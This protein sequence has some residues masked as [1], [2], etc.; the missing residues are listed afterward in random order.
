MGGQPQAQDVPDFVHLHVHTHFS[1]LDGACRLE[2]LVDEA[3]ADGQRALGVTDH[4]NL[5]GAVPFYQACTAKGLKPI[6]GIEGYLAERSRLERANPEDN[7]TFHL[8]LLARNDAGWRNLIKLSSLAFKEGF[9]RRPR[10]DKEVLARHS[11]GIVCLTGCL[12]GEI[13]QHIL[14]GDADGA[15][16]SA[17]SFVDIFGREDVYL[18]VMDNGYEGQRRAIEGLRRI[19]DDLGLQLV[20]TNDVHYVR[21]TDAKAQDILLC[22]N[23][24]KTVLEENRFRM[25]S[26]ELFF[27]TRAQMWDVFRDLPDA[28]RAT[29]EI[30]ERCDVRLDFGTYHLP[31]FEPDTGEG[32]DALFDRLL[33][34]GLRRLYDPVTDAVRRRLEYEKD[35]IRKLG[36][37]SYFLITWDFIRY[38]RDNGIPVGP[39]RGSAAG[40]L[41]AYCLGI[42]RLDPLRYDLL[43]ERFLNAERVSMPDIDVDFCR[44]KREQVIDYVRGRYGDENVAQII[45]FGTMAS[46]GVIRD[47]GRALDI[48][49]PEVD[50]IAKKVPNGPGASLQK[51]LEQDTEL[52]EIL[53]SGPDKER[54]FDISLRLEGLCRHASTHA[55]GVVI[56]DRPLDE[57][58]P[59]YRNGDDITTQWQMTDLEAVGLLK[60]DFLGLKTLTILD[61]ARRLIRVHHGQDV[62]LDRIPLDD[63]A[64]YRL[65]QSG[66]TLGVFQLESE[67]MQDLIRRLRPDTFE[68]VIASIA[69]YRP[70]PLQSGMVDMYVKRKH[71][72]ERVTYPHDSLR[73]LLESTYG[74]I[75]YQ[76]QVMLISHR[77]AGFSLNEADSLRKAMGK[78]KPEVMAGY[79]SKF[80]DGAVANGHDRRMADELFTTME[81]FAGYG[82]NKSHSAAYAVLTYQTAWLKANWPVEFMCALMTCDMGL[83][84]KV[85]EFVEEARRM[86]IEVLPPD[87]NRSQVRFSEEDRR[88]RYGLGAIKGMGTL[89]ATA[90]VE[91]RAKGGPYLDLPDLCHRW[92]PAQANRTC[93]EVLAKAGAFDSTGWT[94]RACFEQHPEL[95]RQAQSVLAEL[96]KGQ[97]LLF[98]GG[99]GSGGARERAPVPDVPE[100]DER[101]KLAREKEALGFYLSGHPFRKRGAFWSRLAGCDS[102]GIRDLHGQGKADELVVAGMISAVRR[103]II[104][105]GRNAGQRMAR[106]RLEDL[107]GQVSATVFARQYQELKERLVE[108][109]LVFCRGRLDARSEE[110]AIL[111]EDIVPAQD[112]VARNVDSLVLRLD[113]GRHDPA[114]LT[115]LQ[116]L[117]RRHHGRHRLIFQVPT[118]DGGT[119]RLLADPEFRVTL[120]DELLDGIAEILGPEAM[121]YTKV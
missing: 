12:G 51:A 59:L 93:Y 80:V 62:D 111:V 21:G 31:V 16:R 107:H 114:R 78:K 99:G 96:R 120:S 61:E 39:G 69:L 42:T 77:L 6:L 100:W 84:D 4:G 67:G 64:T 108:D 28:L 82:F 29:V 15:L 121:S 48:P 46:R 35:V 79:R 49:L 63:P 101:D 110:P 65:L 105:S 92:D 3:L 90:L 115:P 8:T 95:L 88:I 14:R 34:E 76:E 18:E 103:I 102:R 36:F 32:P 71:G 68:D 17:G 85:H 57:L 30:A 70:G 66:E 5:F 47:V 118:A 23:T 91:E 73:S 37:V 117:V 86:G 81:Y 87:L 53:G 119:C 25:E 50:Q 74:V 112:Y 55:A 72:Q 13:N 97:N 75:V 58:V 9:Y 33:E 89:V 56:A 45:T 41:V 20:A 98:F 10:F 104:K 109:A 1:L 94:R 26:E 60:V 2:A 40:S 83:T 11:E 27:K 22:I 116:D 44:D 38:A 19:Q 43:F 52:K 113:E 24:G 106:F 7:R 54:L